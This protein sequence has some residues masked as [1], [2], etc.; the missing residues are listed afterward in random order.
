M[1]KRIKESIKKNNSMV[2]CGLDPD[3]SKLPYSLMK[4]PPTEAIEL[5]IKKV[6]DVTHENVAAYKIQKAFFDM[7]VGGHNLLL[8][9]VSYIRKKDPHIVVLLDSKIGD[10]NNTMNVYLHTAF[11]NLNVDGVTLNPYMGKDVWDSLAKFS[12]RGGLVLVK[13]SNQSAGIVQNTSLSNGKLLWQYVL[14]I[15]VNEWNNGICLIPVLSSHDDKDLFG[16]RSA[17]PDEMPIFYAGIGAQ[18]A[19]LNNIKHCFDSERNG[20]LV[21]SSRGIL[22]PFKPNVNNWS[23]AIRDACFQLKKMLLEL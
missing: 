23:D 16:I 22:Y 10:I 8:N 9:I 17:M 15:I 7:H 12:D 2:C 4:K 13:T 1:A 14:D 5:F 21:N 11:E 3:L 19:S 20:V 6:V 18:G